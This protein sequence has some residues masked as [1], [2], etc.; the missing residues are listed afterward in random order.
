MPLDRAALQA[1]VEEVGAFRI[2]DR[3]MNRAQAA[4]GGAL[5]RGESPDAAAVRTYL[6]RVRRYFGAFE[7]EAAG[8]LAD[9]D[10]RLARVAQLQFNLTAERGVAARR[11][12]RAQGVLARAAELAAR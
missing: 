11:V 4:L 5:E 2:R 3:A 1:L 7:R 8:R 9:V 12:E 6:E 10:R